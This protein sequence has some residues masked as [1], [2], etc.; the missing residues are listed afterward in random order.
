[1][2]EGCTATD[3]VLT[4]TQML[5][6]KGVVGKFVEFYGAGLSALSVAD[7]AT[8]ANMAP[9]YGATM[10]F[11]PVDT[12]RS[13]ICASPIAMPQLIALVEAYSKEQGCS[14]PTTRPIRSLCRHAGTGSGDVCR[15]WPGRSARRIAST[16]PM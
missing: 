6:K 16:C 15:R 11:F 2:P 12:R 3:L 14:A 13:L 5:R 9:E 10:G 7:R 8:V 1:M 4:I